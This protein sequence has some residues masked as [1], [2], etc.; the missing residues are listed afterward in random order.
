MSDVPEPVRP[1][2]LVRRR[3]PKPVREAGADAAIPSEAQDAIKG[4][5]MM[6]AGA[7]LVAKAAAGL[8]AL[9]AAVIH[10]FSR[11]SPHG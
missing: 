2:R 3:R 8:I 10:L 4:L 9:G 11:Q 7:T 5:T 6:V 1:R